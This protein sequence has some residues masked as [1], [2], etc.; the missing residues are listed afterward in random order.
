M[1][2]LAVG[3]EKSFGSTMAVVMRA[4]AVDVR[5]AIVPDSGHWVM[6][7]NPVFT[8]AL[9]SGFLRESGKA[10]DAP[11]KEALAK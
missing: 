11:M 2:V 10:S 8:V 1:P 7:E 9:V 6:D 4:A 3:G 5:E